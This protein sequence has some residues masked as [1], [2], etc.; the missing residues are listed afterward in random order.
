MAYQV[1]LVDDEAEVL[2]ALADVLEERFVVHCA[3]DGSR[4]PVE[5]GLTPVPTAR[6]IFVVASVVEW[7]PGR[8]D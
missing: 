8:R 1:L 3:S 6:G 5:V 7:Q 2:R 4:F